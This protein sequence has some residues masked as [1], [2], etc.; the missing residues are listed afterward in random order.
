M[1]VSILHRVLG[2]GVAIVGLPLF[3]WWLAAVAAGQDSYTYFMSWFS[4]GVWKYLGYLLLV[5][6]SWSVLQ[7][8]MTGVRHFVLD[9]GAGYE[10]KRNKTGAL[11]TM[12]ASLVLTALLWGYIL[13]V[14]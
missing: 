3:V 5:G 12:V 1:L 6:L 13:G 14:K 9:T 8:M 4:D 11:M 2:V 10:L 7:H